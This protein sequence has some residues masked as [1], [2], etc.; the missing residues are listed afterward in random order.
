MKMLAS[1]VAAA[2]AAAAMPEVLTA[3]ASASGWMATNDNRPNII[4]IMAGTLCLLV[5]FAGGA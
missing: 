4:W 1:I 3:S 2:A 5:R